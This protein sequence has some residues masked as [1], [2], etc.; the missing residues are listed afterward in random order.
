MCHGRKPV[1]RNSV[2]IPAPVGRKIDGVHLSLSP[3]W[4]WKSRTTVNPGL[5]PGATL[6]RRFAAKTMR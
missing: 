3:L 1:D 4:G 2:E 6:C 5:A